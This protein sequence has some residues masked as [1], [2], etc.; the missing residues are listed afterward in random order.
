MRCNIFKDSPKMH[1]PKTLVKDY[2]IECILA[3]GTTKN[4]DVSQNIKRMND[5]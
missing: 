5:L 2:T 3:D 1:L 4:I